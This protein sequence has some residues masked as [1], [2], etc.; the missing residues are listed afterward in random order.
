MM[1]KKTI[2]PSEIFQAMTS[3]KSTSSYIISFRCFGSS[4]LQRT[5]SNSITPNLQEQETG[6]RIKLPN[7]ELHPDYV[8]F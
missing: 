2:S 8:I 6:K 5:S 1:A 7:A 3:V 4:S